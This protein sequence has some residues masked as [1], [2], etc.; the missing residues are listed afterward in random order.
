MDHDR[1]NITT[2]SMSCGILELSRINED[3]TGVLYALGSR[4]Y[5]PSRGNPC[6]FFIFSD[7]ADG[8]DTASSRLCGLIGELKL[9]SV[10][11]SPLTENPRTGN[12]IVT[13]T[14]AIDH[15]V[16][17]KY[18]AKKRSEKLLKVGS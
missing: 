18:Y 10:T 8:G 9:G 12:I 5:H 14:W 17:K 2:T 11:M 15:A 7:V 3:T 16:F 13:Y 4:L 6:A 1:V